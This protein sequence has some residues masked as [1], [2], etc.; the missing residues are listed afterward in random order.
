MAI[1]VTS[2][3]LLSMIVSID[4]GKQ[5]QPEPKEPLLT[6]LLQLRVQY[7]LPVVRPRSRRKKG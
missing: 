3:G 4:L 1:S 5:I 7:K 6:L 2:A